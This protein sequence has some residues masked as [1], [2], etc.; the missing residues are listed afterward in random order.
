MQQDSLD[1]LKLIRDGPIKSTEYAD[2]MLGDIVTTTK[3]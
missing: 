3:S 1:W 2:T